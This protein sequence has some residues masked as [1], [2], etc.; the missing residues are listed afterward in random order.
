MLGTHTMKDIQNP[1][2]EVGDNQM[3]LG[4]KLVGLH[5]A[6]QNHGIVVVSQAV[7]A[8][9]SAQTVGPNRASRLDGP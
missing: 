7:Q 1:A 4:Q 2:L 3:N 6:S 8:P 5:R 9:V